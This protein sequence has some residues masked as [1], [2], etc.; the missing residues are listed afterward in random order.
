MTS[1]EL[2]KRKKHLSKTF[3]SNQNFILMTNESGRT[4][5]ETPYLLSMCLLS[6]QSLCN[7]LEEKK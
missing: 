5:T 1:S 3:G 6:S 7:F 4:D 2:K